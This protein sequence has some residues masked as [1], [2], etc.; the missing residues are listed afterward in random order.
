VGHSARVKSPRHTSMK[1][2]ADDAPPTDLLVIGAGEDH[3]HICTRFRIGRRTRACTRLLYDPRWTLG[4]R[5]RWPDHVCYADF[6]QKSI[7]IWVSQVVGKIT[8]A[9]KLWAEYYPLPV[10]ETAARRLYAKRGKRCPAGLRG[11]LPF[12]GKEEAYWGVRIEEKHSV[13]DMFGL[14]GPKGWAPSGEEH[15]WLGDFAYSLRGRDG[16]SLTGLV[17]E[18]ATWW[19]DFS[20]ESV[21]GRP[22][23]SGTWTSAEEFESEL[24]AAVDNLHRQGDRPTQ[25]KVANLLHCD[26]ST[27]KRWLKRI[28]TSWRDIRVL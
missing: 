24:R 3:C 25:E 5:K 4:Q 19:R 15:L 13:V 2:L 10:G 11:L 6:M 14:K 27:L 20:V 17:D 26:M 23:G 9:I 16:T 8:P 12:R 18:S 21:L 1:R 28:N 7:E 22:S